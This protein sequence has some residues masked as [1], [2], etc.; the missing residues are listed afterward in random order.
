MAIL[1]PCGLIVTGSDRGEAWAVL[2]QHQ[3]GCGA[4]GFVAYETGLDVIEATKR[5]ERIKATNTEARK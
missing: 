3:V 4:S 1:C 2:N 5:V